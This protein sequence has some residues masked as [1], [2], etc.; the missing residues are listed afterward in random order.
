VD[1]FV[2]TAAVEFRPIQTQHDVPEGHRGR[3]TGEG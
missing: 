3:A 2:A 1:A